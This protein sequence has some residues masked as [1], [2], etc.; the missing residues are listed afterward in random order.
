MDAVS[1]IVLRGSDHLPSWES[2][3]VALASSFVG[4]KNCMNAQ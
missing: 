2:I 1:P 3:Y 4:Y